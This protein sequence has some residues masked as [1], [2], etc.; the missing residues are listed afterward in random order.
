MKHFLLS[1]S[2]L[3]VGISAL[4]AATPVTT[5]ESGK[6]YYISCAYTD[7]YLALG[8]NH[9]SSCELY[10]VA[11]TAGVSTDGYWYIQ[12]NGS[13]YTFKNAATGQYLAWTETR[14]T[15]V[16]YMTLQDDVDDNAL[17]TINNY[18]SYATIQSVAAPTYYWN[19][20]TDGTYLMGCYDG[21]IS[22]NGRMYIYAEGDGD[23]GSTDESSDAIW[24]SGNVYV[25]HN[26]NDF[27]YIVYNPEVITTA[28]V[29]AGFSNASRT[30]ANDAFREDMD[31]ANENN[32]WRVI[33]NASGEVAFYNI[34]KQQYLY[35]NTTMSYYGSSSL[36]FTFSA[37]PTYFTPEERKEGIYVFKVSVRSGGSFGPGGYSY[38]TTY[39]LC[40]APQ[41]A[42]G[43]T[44]LLYTAIDDEGSQF[45][46]VEAN[47]DAIRITDLTLG[48]TAI[49]MPV[50]KSYKLPTTILPTD[51]TN[52]RLAWTTNNSA[53][54]SVA[55]DGTL[56]ATGIGTAT[57]T[58]TTRD[59]SHISQ[60]CTITVYEPTASE[61]TGEV[62]YVLQSSGALDAFPEQ[63]IASRTDDAE[64]GLVV[65]TTDGQTFTYLPLEV[66]SAS[67]D[68]PTDLPTLI[69]YKFNNK[70]NDQLPADVIV[71]ETILPD[72]TIGIPE[73]IN[74]TVGSAIGKRLTASFNT[75]SEDATVY[76]NGVEQVSK[77]TRMRFD[78]DIIY[79]VA[80]RAYKMYTSTA[81]TADI[82][83]VSDADNPVV[84]VSATEDATYE[85]VPYGRKYTV[86]VDWATDNP[87]YQYNVPVVYITLDGGA[88]ISNITKASYVTATI[89]ID[90]AGVYPDFPETAV[91]IKGRGNS[92]WSTN[93]TGSK[94]PYRLKFDTKQKVF[95]LKKGKSWV[96]LAN[97]QT[98]SMTTNAL[99]MKMADMVQSVGCNHI[100]P[101][102]LYINGEYRG[103]YNFTEKVGFSNNSID[104]ADE[105]EAFMLELDTY[106]DE[107]YYTD[108]AYRIYTKIH[109]PDLED[110]VDETTRTN[111]LN[112]ILQHWREF[113][114]AVYNND[115]FESWIDID[116]FVRAM[117]VT[118]LS[119]NQEL[120][121]P[122]SWFLYNEHALASDGL[123]GFT[124][125]YESPY[126]F[127]PV[128]DFD[129]AYG[130][131]GS[132]TYFI[133]KAEED[134]FNSSGSGTPFFRQL[135]RG[136]EEVQKAYYSL[137][138]QFMTEGGLEELVE[139]CDDYYNYVNPSF[140][141]NASKWTDGTNYATQTANS[142]TWL[143]TRANYIFNNLTAYDLSDEEQAE[144]PGNGDAN[145]D[146]YI[147]T[148][149]VVCIIN[150][151]L[152]IV[153]DNF[154]IRQADT[155]GNSLVTMKDA[156]AVIRMVMEQRSSSTRQLRLPSAEAA[157]RPATFVASVGEEAQMPLSLAIAE[158]SYSALQFDVVV[159]EGMQ[160]LG[161]S[162]PEE[163]NGYS[164]ATSRLDDRHYR[165]SFY[166]A[167]NNT[168]PV[169]ILSLQLNLIA[170]EMIAED[171]RIVSITNA[172]LVDDEAEDNRLNSVSVRFHMPDEATSIQLLQGRA[173]QA[174]A[175]SE[176]YDLQGR[177]VTTL[178]Q[179]GIY[180]VNGKKVVF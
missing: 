113:T 167:A 34:G 95:N 81:G 147:T 112:A 32:Q 130:Y 10:Y 136:S 170:D 26:V 115:D 80:P 17:W 57:I 92:S 70:Y 143:T 116:A 59:G 67:N 119:R 15:T 89:R 47:T 72:G 76:V 62:F 137:W 105:S 149:D 161:V 165:V 64:S 22:D 100:V 73:D 24:D 108:N 146:G 179:G 104:L 60:T 177:R 40:A 33:T 86:H 160:L 144:A 4:N 133:N 166:A 7:G 163:L 61:P 41:Q 154:E 44:V 159:P 77:K 150:H 94:N 46:L 142:K 16:K 38:D 18:S 84:L 178:Q 39:Y 107:T 135:L 173:A 2:L 156:A 27:G 121:H 11:G 101:V 168:M 78:H 91:N 124:L 36:N 118:D 21:A 52:Q 1:F 79:T 153:N 25:I 68:A 157:L 155:D 30:C 9:Y 23:S 3:L 87:N 29:V 169:G 158:G 131:D 56:T 13:G 88:T 43:S 98:G 129:W 176:V 103:S 128:W 63:Y 127:G 120:K 31:E 125:N 110:I 66:V 106:T 75:S 148:A 90:G 151:V 51:A 138:H 14:S 82:I 35:V 139:Y 83:D 109:E 145:G 152:G 111:M 140:V 122:K 97:K 134:I 164:S 74:L 45:E 53:V 126:V 162:L 123:D 71:E 28:P 65:T 58:A 48:S 174:V 85:W 171:T 180:I 19:L 99:A 5:F 49:R 102:E 54:V 114:Y 172:M 50:G 8:S 141:H 12:N 117:F 69:S 93:L 96:L 6:K 175:S 20:R 55:T 42:A 37:T 132:Y